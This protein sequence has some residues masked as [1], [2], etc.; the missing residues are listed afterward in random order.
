[1]SESR[2][3]TFIMAICLVFLAA[4]SRFFPHPYNF[5]AIGAMSLF[6]GANIRNKT[7]A[8]FIPLCAMF[9]SD[10]FFG[11]HA[12]M[13]AIYLSFMLTV[14]I[15]MKIS[16]RQHPVIVAGASIISSVIF[17]LVTN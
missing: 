2:N 3:K 1:M 17:F 5:T 6:A 7:F 9:L 10:L 12:G 13:P 11:L 16:S 15:G 4:L 14:Y 8:F